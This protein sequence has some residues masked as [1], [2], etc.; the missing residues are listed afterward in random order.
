M[1][2]ALL[3][4]RCQWAVKSEGQAERRKAWVHWEI[5]VVRECAMY[6]GQY[7]GH[8]IEKL[9]RLKLAPWLLSE[10]MWSTLS[11]SPLPPPIRFT[12]FSKQN[13]DRMREGVDL[14]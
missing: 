9:D 14:C 13:L 3:G 6:L 7:T 10:A 8:G 5:W 4:V 11:L 12:Y 2:R 1:T